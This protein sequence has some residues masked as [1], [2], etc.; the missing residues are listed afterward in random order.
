M[1]KYRVTILH[2]A[3]TSHE[4]TADSETSAVDLALDDAHVTLCH[5]CSNEMDLGDPICA[6]GIENLETGEY[7]QDVDP[8]FEVVAL[9]ARVAELEAQLAERGA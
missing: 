3:C 8:G 9:R 4:V 7:N 1:T 6:V 5:Q 2:D